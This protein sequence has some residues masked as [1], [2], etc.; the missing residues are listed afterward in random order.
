M[1]N[2]VNMAVPI[3][4]SGHDVPLMPAPFGHPRTLMWIK[5]EEASPAVKTGSQFVITICFGRR[6]PPLAGA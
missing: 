4:A 3:L 5:V 6:F 2:G 1:I